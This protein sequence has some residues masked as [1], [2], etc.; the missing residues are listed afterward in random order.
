LQIYDEGVNATSRRHF[1]ALLGATGL[2]AAVTPS[3]LAAPFAAP[4]SA[5][6]PFSFLFVT[7]AHLQPELNG[8]IGTDM[9]F[10]KARTIKADFAINGGDHVFDAL[11]VPKQRALALFDLYDKTEQDLGLK[12]HHVIGNHDVLGVYPASG[13]A[14]D[15]PLYGKK[16][17]EERFG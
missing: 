14:E 10:K 5:Q 12:L 6:E 8:L 1:L 7:D 9:A 3:V 2:S 15:D 4:A 13:I 17:F 11:G 16:L